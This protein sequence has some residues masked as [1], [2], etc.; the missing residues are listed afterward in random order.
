MD[1]RDPSTVV[2]RPKLEVWRDGN[3][4]IV[5]AGKFPEDES[6]VGCGDTIPDAFRDFAAQLDQLDGLQIEQAFGKAKLE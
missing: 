2:F 6:V 4:W 1:D 5:C 3:S